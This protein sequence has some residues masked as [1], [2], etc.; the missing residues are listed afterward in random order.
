MCVCV[1]CESEKKLGLLGMLACMY[2]V[3]QLYNS[4]Q[5]VQLPQHVGGCWYR[6]PFRFGRKVKEVLGMGSASYASKCLGHSFDLEVVVLEGKGR[7]DGEQVRQKLCP[8]QLQRC[9]DHYIQ[10]RHG[11]SMRNLHLTRVEKNI[12]ICETIFSLDGYKSQI[13][14]PPEPTGITFE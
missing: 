4:V 6:L 7:E 9:I 1:W 11:Y 5:K 8:S 14:L 13:R 2:L 3:S 10:S 12:N